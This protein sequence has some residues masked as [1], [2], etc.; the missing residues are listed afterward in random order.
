MVL[1][2]Y[3]LFQFIIIG[4]FLFLI[5]IIIISLVVNYNLLTKKQILAEQ[6]KKKNKINI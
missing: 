6:L 3:Y 1:Y 4:I 5:M 2:E